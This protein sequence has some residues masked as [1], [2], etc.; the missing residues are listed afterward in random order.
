MQHSPDVQTSC[1]INH[2]IRTKTICQNKVF[3][4]SD[5]TIDVA[6]G[7]EVH[8]RIVA[9]H[10]RFD[11]AR[12]ANIA[13][14][15]L[16]SRTVVNIFQSRKIAGICQRVVNSYFMISVCEHPSHIIRTDKTGAASYKNLH[17]ELSPH[18]PKGAHLRIDRVAGW[19]RGIAVR[20]NWFGDSPI[21]FNCLVVICK[22]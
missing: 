19:V 13:F 14:H 16:E 1:R 18:R 11:I 3:A 22:P 20:Q 5:R 17:F 7:G 9:S 6:F 2:D 4:A 12:L 10:R 8:D 15:K 21:G